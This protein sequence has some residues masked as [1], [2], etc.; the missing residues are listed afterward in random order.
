MVL[1]LFI[2]VFLLSGGSLEM[3]RKRHGKYFLLQRCS[4]IKFTGSILDLGV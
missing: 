3:L 1:Y 4:V 2:H